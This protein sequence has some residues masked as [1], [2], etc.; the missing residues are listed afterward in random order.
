M[1]NRWY[2]IYEVGM[3]IGDDQSECT[4]KWI[5]CVKVESLK[6]PTQFYG[7]LMVYILWIRL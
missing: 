1:E 4:L 5:G 6:K 7:G 3:L 2:A